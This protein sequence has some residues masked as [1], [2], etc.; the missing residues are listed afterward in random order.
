MGKGGDGPVDWENRRLGCQ[1]KGVGWYGQEG[2]QSL[3]KWVEK[4]PSQLYDR[5]L[6]K[7]LYIAVCRMVNTHTGRTEGL[8]ETAALWSHQGQKIL[9]D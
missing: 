8:Q 4:E 6:L 2:P 1:A 9:V 5:M 7:F 3:H